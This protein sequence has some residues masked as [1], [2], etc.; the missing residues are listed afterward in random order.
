MKHKTSVAFD[1]K[2]I[3]GI[4]ELLRGGTFRNKSHVVE[5]AVQKLLKESIGEKEE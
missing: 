4:L 2:T 3:F 1:E 5:F